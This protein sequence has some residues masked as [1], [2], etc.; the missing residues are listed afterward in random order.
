LLKQ[1]KQP[2]S[3]RIAAPVFA[4]AAIDLPAQRFETWL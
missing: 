2:E 3:R 1:N 4:G